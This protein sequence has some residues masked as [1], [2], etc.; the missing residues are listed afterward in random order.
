MFKNLLVP[1]SGESITK[2]ELK[3]VIKLA[4]T[5]GA[6]I[7]LVFVTD[8]VM[9]YSSSEV[10]SVLALSA[11]EYQKVSAEFAKK[12]FAKAKA[13]IGSDIP[14]AEFHILH[15]NIS[16]GIL[17]AAKKAKADVI[18]MASHKRSGIR[19][20]FLRSEAQEVILHSKLPVLIL[21]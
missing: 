9:P 2:A 1:I 17:E 4:L 21:G 12:L 14:V 7:S 16:D 8:P 10:Q 18:V 5:D 13:V 20:I 15:P 11:R 19:G 6:K 3:A